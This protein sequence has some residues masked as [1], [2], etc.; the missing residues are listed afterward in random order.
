MLTDPI[1]NM[2]TIIRNG[3]SSNKLEVIVPSSKFKVSILEILKKENYIS[4]FQVTTEGVK[5]TITIKLKYQDKKPVI[6][7]IKK[8]SK[9]GMKMYVN[10]QQIPRPLKGMGLVVISTSQGVISGKDAWRKQI[11]GELICEVY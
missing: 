7:H 8:F 6:S 2:L 11:G 10:Y 9:P 3:L 5:S 1:A 4:D